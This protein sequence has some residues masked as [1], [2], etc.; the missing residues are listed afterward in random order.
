MIDGVIAVF[1]PVDYTSHDVVAKLRRILHMKR[2]G[3]T[4]TLDP[5]VTGVLPICLGKATRLVE[6]IQDLPKAYECVLRIGQAS[7]TEDASGEIIVNH[8]DRVS[9]TEED[10]AQVLQSFIGEIEQVPPMYSA[11]KVNGKRLYELAR[12]G[13]VVERKARRVQIYRMDLIHID[14]EK[15]YPEVRFKVQCSKGTYIRTLCVD[16]GRALGYPA[17]MAELI[18]TSSGHFELDQCLSLEDIAEHAEHQRLEE[19]VIPMDEAVNHLP[20]LQIKQEYALRATQGQKLSLHVLNDVE[21]LTDDE[22][23]NYRLYDSNKNFIGIFTVDITNQTIKP[24]KV[25]I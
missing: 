3:H 19:I 20:K 8:T 1:K 15:R 23:S 7:D 22:R 10:I 11:V 24:V 4:G 14:L 6:Y 16:I 21:Q 17:L 18:R 25:F 12:Q 5:S 2:I 9:C 13:E